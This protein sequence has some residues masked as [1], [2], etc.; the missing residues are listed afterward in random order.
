MISRVLW[1]GLDKIFITFTGGMK[2]GRVENMLMNKTSIQND[3]LEKTSE[4]EMM[5]C[6]RDKGKIMAMWWQSAEQLCNNFIC[7]SLGIVVACQI[8]G[9]LYMLYSWT[10]YFKKKCGITENK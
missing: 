10:I 2:L 3:I 7:K 5:K 4:W 6:N 9:L 1:Y 8:R